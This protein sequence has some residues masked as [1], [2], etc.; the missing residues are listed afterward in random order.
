MIFKRTSLLGVSRTLSQYNLVTADVLIGYS[1]DIDWA[2][3][4]KFG[5]YIQE[6]KIWREQLPISL[7]TIGISIYCSSCLRIFFNH[8]LQT[9][10]HLSKMP[11]CYEVTR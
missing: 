1:S 9:L 10:T 6:L 2:E 3:M 5:M 11:V 7:P 8:T 4:S